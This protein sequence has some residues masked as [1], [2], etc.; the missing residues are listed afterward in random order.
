MRFA[1]PE[2][3]SGGLAAERGEAGGA[4]R[5]GRWR[6]ARRRWVT[7]TATPPSRRARLARRCRP[8]ARCAARSTAWSPARCARSARPRPGDAHSSERMRRSVS[9]T[10]NRTEVLPAFMRSAYEE[11]GAGQRL[12]GSAHLTVATSAAP[13]AAHHGVCTHTTRC[14]SQD[15]RLVSRPARLH[16]PWRG[17]LSLPCRATV[18]RLWASARARARQARN[19]F[20]AVR[21]P[22]HHAGPVGI[23]T[24]AN[25]PHGSLGFCLLNNL[26]IGAAYAVSTYR[27]AGA[28]PPTRL[29]RG[30]AGVAQP[31]QTS[32][33]DNTCE[34][35]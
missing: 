25:D 29:R 1:G 17:V 14:V 13:N 4:R 28:P 19:A 22:G 32:R 8:R 3:L 10:Y 2:G 15:P 21:P 11:A 12:P 35:R 27:A 24:C 31:G 20:C 6:T 18:C 26:A 9:R 33:E 23:V 16:R 30:V 34:G 5:A 7:W